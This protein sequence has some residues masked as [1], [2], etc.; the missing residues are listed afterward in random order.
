MV[1]VLLVFALVGLVLLPVYG[2]FYLVC[3]ILGTVR[4]SNGEPWRYPL[5]VRIIT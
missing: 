4:A 1:F 5:T 2:L 3:V